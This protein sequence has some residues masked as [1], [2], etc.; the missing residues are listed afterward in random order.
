L[1]APIRITEYARLRGV[2]DEAVRKA[3]RSGRLKS[4]VV[5]VKDKPWIGDVLLANR[6]W[7]LNTDTKHHRKDA[8]PPFTE[9]VPLGSLATAPARAAFNRKVKATHRPPSADTS[10]WINPNVDPSEFDDP[11]QIDPTTGVPRVMVSRARKEHFDAVHAQAKAELLAGT[12]VNREEVTRTAFNVAREVRDALFLI[13]DRLAD[14]LATMNDP[15]QISAYL[16]TEF[17]NALTKLAGEIVLER[18]DVG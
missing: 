1:A 4:C 2:S 8:P 9:P 13:K 3:I 7:D 17:R 5:M 10:S 15:N 11:N 12:Q 18:P 14:E 6:E 16:D